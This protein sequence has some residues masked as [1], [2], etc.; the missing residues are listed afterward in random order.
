MQMNKKPILVVGSIAI[1]NTIYTSSLPQAGTTTLAN[2]YITNI[3]GKGANQACAALFLNGNV[4]F[5]GAVGKDQNG[6]NVKKRLSE[7]GLNYY[8][9]ESEEPTGVAF[10]ILEETS[11]ENRLLIVQGANLDIQKEDLDNCD[12]LFVDNGILLTQFETSISCIEHVIKK[13]HE[14][15][16]LLVVNPAPYKEIDE[17]YFKYIDYLVPN[18]H[19][20]EQLT[21]IFNIEEAS[22]SLLNKGVK[23]VIVTLG[24]KGSFFIN[25]EESFYVAPHKVKAID[26]TAAGDSY[27]GALVTMLSEGKDIKEAMEFASLASSITV[28]RKGAIQSLP[29]INELKQKQKSPS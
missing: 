16:M 27:L 9:K 15:N 18:E 28:T 2:S 21:N 7:L 12:D 19:E 22:K 10:I 24:E 8:I 11:G 5:I 26:T 17:K 3:G 6:Q 13:A 23:N 20:L 1:D 25:K 4:S 29:K 14:H